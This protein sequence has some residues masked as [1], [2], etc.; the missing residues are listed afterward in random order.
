MRL[1]AFFVSQLRDGEKQ[2]RFLLP[3]RF[4]IFAIRGDL[5]HH[6]GE[7]SC[8]RRLPFWRGKDFLSSRGLPIEPRGDSSGHCLP[9]LEPGG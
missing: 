6:L 7:V 4:V 1:S 9:T 5:G 3:M 2:L 8:G